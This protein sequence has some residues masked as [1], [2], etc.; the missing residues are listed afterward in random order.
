M[1]NQLLDGGDDRL[2][3]QKWSRATKCS[4]ETAA[5]DIGELV[6]RGVLIQTDKAGRSQEFR[7]A[8]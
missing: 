4:A 1:I 3:K 7:L 6:D 5:R 8:Q 2:T